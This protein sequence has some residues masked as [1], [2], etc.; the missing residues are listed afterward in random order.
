MSVDLTK[1]RILVIDDE[2]FTLQIL[3]RILFEI[4]IVT[5]T[6]ADDGFDGLTK[7]SNARNAFDMVICDLEMP[8]MDGLE[9]VRR[10]REKKYLPN[11]NI[12]ILIV[13]SHSET[14]NVQSAIKA[15]IHGY[16][17]KPVSKTQLEKRIVA[18]LT[19]PEIGA[20]KFK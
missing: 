20:E 16:L 13:T 19:S 6:T 17:V 12:P 10:L 9:F 18:A 1:L 5:V 11:S 14:V 3:Q 15:G 4:G 7:F 8:N 2:S